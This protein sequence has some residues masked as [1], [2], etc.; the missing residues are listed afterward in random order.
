MKV[1]AQDY[2]RMRAW[3][4]HM[5]SATFPP[6]GFRRDDG[7]LASLD[8]VAARFPARARQGLSM[9]INDLIEMTDGWPKEQ[10]ASTDLALT[11]AGLPS[12]S[13]MRKRLSKAVQRAVRRG[14]IKDDV[15]YYAVR[16][17]AE[18]SGDGQQ[19]LW[20]LL[21]AYEPSTAG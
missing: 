8:A 1:Q 2:D 15:E 9:A 14:R 12:L 21:A 3:F 4:A 18:L 20:L 13:E 16:N 17:A 10:V 5:V 7:P 19:P 6:D 11:K